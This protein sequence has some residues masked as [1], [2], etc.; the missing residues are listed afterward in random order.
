MTRALPGAESA[1]DAIERVAEA[2]LP[3]QELLEEVMQRVDTVVPSDG[4]F[5]GATDPD[6]ILS[7]GAGIVRDL[8]YDQCQP[9]W[10]YEFRVPDYVKFRDIAQSGRAVA[11]LHEATGGRPDRS[12]R[13]REYGTATGFRSEVRA[14]FSAGNSTWGVGQFNR[15]GDSPRYSEDEQAW[16][17]RVAPVVGRALRQALIAQPAASPAD[18]GPGIVV[19]DTEGVTV[20]ATSEATAWFDEVDHEQ[21]LMPFEA[22]AY[23]ARVRASVEGEADETVPRARLRTRKGVWLSMHASMLQGTDHLA[24][25]IEPAK[26]SEVAPLIVEAYG[27]TQ[28]EL[29]V[30]RAISRGLGTAEIAAQLFVSQHTVRD[31]V[32]SVFEKVGVSSRGELVAKVFADHYSPVLKHAD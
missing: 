21:S 23:A 20:S 28:R 13:W 7:L 6:T 1:F 16:L 22:T 30:T 4:Y 31:H 17:E 14:V 2:G 24:L 5:V 25:V 9:T 19:L 27:F 3:A 26:A 11:D 8:P 12:P 10:D 15:L 29:D 18:R 32:K